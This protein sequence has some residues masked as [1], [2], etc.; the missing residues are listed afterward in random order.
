V[1]T[2][3]EELKPDSVAVKVTLDPSGD[4]VPVRVTVGAGRNSDIV[5]IPIGVILSV[6][7]EVTVPFKAKVSG[8]SKIASTNAG[9]FTVVEPV[10]APAGIV[11]VTGAV[12]DE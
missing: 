3:F 7:P 5:P 6:L 2:T 11:I 12:I 10:I 9:T 1:R 8:P 4:V